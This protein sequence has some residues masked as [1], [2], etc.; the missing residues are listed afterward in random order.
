MTVAENLIVVVAGSKQTGCLE[1][2]VV[3]VD[4]DVVELEN[5]CNDVFEVVVVAV[6][7]IELGQLFDL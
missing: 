4:V 2:V 7:E 6:V 5:Y 1:F 3:D